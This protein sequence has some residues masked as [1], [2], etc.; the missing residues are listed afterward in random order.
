MTTQII[1]NNGSLAAQ[2]SFESNGDTVRIT[3]FDYGEIRF[4]V[5]RMNCW[6]EVPYM[7]RF[8]PRVK[9]CLT[10]LRKF[11]TNSPKGQSQ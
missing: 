9:Q 11:K 4:E 6:Q 8:G 10:A 3:T 7:D 5:L 1:R 2:G